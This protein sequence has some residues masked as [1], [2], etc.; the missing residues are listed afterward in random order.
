MHLLG[1]GNMPRRYADPYHFSCFADM[2]PLNK[3]ISICAFASMAAQMIFALNFITVCSG[4]SV[5]AVTPGTPIRWSGQ[6][7]ARLAMATL[8]SNRS[9]IAGHYEYSDPAVASATSV[10]KP[11]AR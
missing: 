11:S 7:P 1:A 2:Q 5:L 6:L 8:I 4:A 3:F 10:R 9:F